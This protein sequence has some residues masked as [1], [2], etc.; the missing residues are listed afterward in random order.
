MLLLIQVNKFQDLH[1]VCIICI[2]NIIEY[3]ICDSN[4]TKTIY[5]LEKLYF[6]FVIRLFSLMKRSDT[7]SL[8]DDLLVR[9]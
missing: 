2:K 5:E 8:E 4:L 7:L 1:I 9:S 3:V 6:A